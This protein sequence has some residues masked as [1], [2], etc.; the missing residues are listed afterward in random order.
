MDVDDLVAAL[1]DA[2]V[3]A[4]FGRSRKPRDV[5]WL[6]EINATVAPLRLPEQLVRF[7]QL[8]DPASLRATVFPRFVDPPFALRHWRTQREELPNLEPRNLLL[9]GYESWNC[10]WIELDDQEG[11]GGTLFDGRL[12][13][14]AFWR[15]Y[16]SLADWLARILELIAVGSVDEWG[17]AEDPYLRI[18][19]PDDDRALAAPRE[20]PPSPVYRDQVEIGRA[21]LEWP[22]RWQRASGINPADAEPG[23]RS[24]G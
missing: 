16:N 1:D 19:D 8:V 14:D 17:R 21:P 4:G 15:R 23:S 22:V 10:M 18:V 20:L 9:V 3:E 2:L 5:A 7:W 11:R 24:A 12:D 6:A 13:A